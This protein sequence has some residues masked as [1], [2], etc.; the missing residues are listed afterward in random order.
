M[1]D[2]LPE[3]AA[4]RL[5]VGEL[6]RPGGGERLGPK[7]PLLSLLA[8]VSVENDAVAEDEDS[9]RRVEDDEDVLE[10]GVHVVQVPDD[11]GHAQEIAEEE[12]VAKPRPDLG[13]TI[14]VAQSISLDVRGREKVNTGCTAQ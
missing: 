8:D 9:A 10:G 11:P 1:A 14:R 7:L 12:E 2:S 4:A 3:V 6:G 13:V 5:V